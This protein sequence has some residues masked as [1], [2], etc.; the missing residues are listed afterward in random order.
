M[1]FKKANDMHDSEQNLLDGQSRGL[2]ECKREWLNF[3]M[4]K[5]PNSRLVPDLIYRSWQRCKEMG[6]DSKK[7]RLVLANPEEMERCLRRNTFLLESSTP[8]MEKVYSLIST[9]RAAMVLAS[10]DGI[11]LKVIPGD[12]LLLSEGML[13]REAYLGT[14]GIATCIEEKAPVEIFGA[15]HFCDSNHELVCSATPILG[16]NQEMVGVLGVTTPIDTFHPH[17]SG[18]LGT[19]AHAIAQ[20][21]RL[22]ELLEEHQT[23]LELLDEGMLA[24][25]TGQRIRAI[26]KTALKMLQLPQAPEL[27]SDINTVIRFSANIKKLIADGASFYDEESTVFQNAGN[28]RI[29]LVISGA[30]SQRSGTLLLTFREMGRMRDFAVRTTGIKAVFNFE[31][32]LGI[33]APIR[34]AVNQAR[35]IAP[36]DSTVLLTGESGTGKELFAQAIHNGSPRAKRPFVVV[37]CGAL[38]RELIQSELFG[39]CEG[40]FTGASRN[41][42]PG[43]FELADG[44]TIFLDEVGEMPLDVQVQL[45]RLIQNREVTRIGSGNSRTVDVRIIAATNRNLEAMVKEH[46]FREDLYYR[47]NVFPISIPPLRDRREDIKIIAEHFVRQTATRSGRHVPRIGSAVLAALESRDWPGNIRELENAL[48][49]AAHMAGDAPVLAIKDFAD[50]DSGASPRQWENPQTE[51]DQLLGALRRNSW[52]VNLACAELGIPR[53]TFYYRMKKA[54]LSRKT[55]PVPEV[56]LNSL[57]EGQLA[58]LLKLAEL[59]GR[60]L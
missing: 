59:V 19:V 37:N 40:A 46:S 34:K 23:L 4:G 39:Y 15:E 42:K 29:P 25:D 52:K 8:I 17:T 41:G 7:P 30:R 10:A 47:L 6:V 16:K 13:Q 48:E 44:G 33:S 11:S 38:P 55:K 43:K 26:N 57:S 49:R 12:G 53:S 24:L 35:K 36:H 3:Q 28:L 22:R 18:M 56:S 50:M 21:L 14:S 32:I 1:A 20:Q 9:S 5:T 31:D 27:G 58:A 54:G 60:T 45:L 2:C 51:K